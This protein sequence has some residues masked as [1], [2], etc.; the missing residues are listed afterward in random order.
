MNAEATKV[1]KDDHGFLYR[2]IGLGDAIQQV[3]QNSIVGG[4]DL[5][6]RDLSCK[7]LNARIDMRTGNVRLMPGNSPHL[8]HE[9]NLLKKRC[10]K[11]ERL[12]RQQDEAMR[13]I[14]MT[15]IT[16]LMPLE[17]DDATD[18]LPT[19]PQRQA[20]ASG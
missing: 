16:T 7:Y 3:H 6:T 9:Y 13:A 19:D 15:C 4:G 10:A 17:N 1:M 2:W 18:K 12:L 11:L 20:D 5:M 8:E 14:A